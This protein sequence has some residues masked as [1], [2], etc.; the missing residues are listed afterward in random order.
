MAKRRLN[1]NEIRLEDRII[2]ATIAVIAVAVGL[3]VWLFFPW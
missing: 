2:Y 3:S 1:D